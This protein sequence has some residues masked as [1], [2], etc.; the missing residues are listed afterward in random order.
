M[1]EKGWPSAQA[2]GDQPPP[3]SRV[4]RSLWLWSSPHRRPPA[5][6]HRG[7]GV[8][9]LHVSDVCELAPPLSSSSSVRLP[10]SPFA[11]PSPF[12]IFFLH[13]PWQP[14]SLLCAGWDEPRLLG[15][16]GR[17]WSSECEFGAATERRQERVGSRGGSW[18]G[19]WA[20]IMSARTGRPRAALDLPCSGQ[21]GTVARQVPSPG[22]VILMPI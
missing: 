10:P 21:D 16:S 4:P 1:S 9:A 3:P 19:A 17:G 8:A 13:Q 14:P 7:G 18:D 12:F 2:D 6:P 22:A 11:A 5:R 15:A 20:S